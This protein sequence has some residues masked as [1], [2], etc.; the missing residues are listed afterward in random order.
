MP[1]E[2][3]TI[4]PNDHHGLALVDSLLAA[5]GITRDGNLDYTCALL[6]GSVIVATGSLFKNTLRC[7]AVSAAHQGE[8][9]MNQLVSHLIATAQ[10]RGATHLFVYTKVK[11]AKHFA[12]LGFHEI[13][14]VGEQLVF[15]EN[16]LHGFAQYRQALTPSAKRPAAAIVM[17]AN[18]F[19]NG[20]RYLIEQAAKAN[21]VVHLF[22][23]S[24]DASLIPYAVRKQLILAGI[25]DLPNVIPHDTGDYL[26]SS[27]TFPSYFLQDSELVIRTQAALDAQLFLQ[28]AT[29][30]SITRRYV[31]TEP[32]STVTGLYNQVLQATLPAAGVALTVVPRLTQAGQ[33]ISASNIRQALHNGDLAAI[34]PWV[35]A[36]TYAFFASAAGQAVIAKLQAVNAVKHY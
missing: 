21:A 7:V 28:I 20:H 2:I 14:R 4:Y 36:T 16:R 19:S 24:D 10:T 27:A 5:E 12:D 15:L 8:G 17:N 23:V 26:I 31:G 33:P 25:A 32:T 3:M 9:L 13:A 18:P 35:P 29:T 34:R 6:Q 11:A 1:P 30:L 22:M